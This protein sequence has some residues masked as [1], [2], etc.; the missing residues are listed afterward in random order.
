M[1]LVLD[2]EQYRH[3]WFDQNVHPAPEHV[4]TVGTAI[5]A[6]TTTAYDVIY[7]DH[8]LGTE[9]LVG[10]DVARYLADHPE[11]CRGASVIVHS[12]NGVSGP[13]IVRE[14]RA[15]GRPAS[16]VPFHGLAAKH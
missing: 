11:C 12:V 4:Y 16:W 2:D 9:P 1:I 15:A 14:L 10:R 13:K 5:S 8:D 6:L 3:D 7:L